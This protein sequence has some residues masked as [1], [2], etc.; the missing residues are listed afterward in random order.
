M[1][2]KKAKNMAHDTTPLFAPFYPSSTPLSVHPSLPSHLSSQSAP[3]LLF[4]PFSINSRAL[5]C[6]SKCSAPHPL[7]VF[8]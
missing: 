2:V 7:L 6:P 3:P 8:P 5:P 4:T 1:N